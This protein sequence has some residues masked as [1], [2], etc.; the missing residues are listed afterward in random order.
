MLKVVTAKSRMGVLS[1]HH[2]QKHTDD[3][4]K[5]KWGVGEGVEEANFRVWK[6]ENDKKT[7]V[8]ICWKRGR[9]TF[10]TC[11]KKAQLISPG[12]ESPHAVYCQ[13]RDN[14]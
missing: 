1:L 11:K 10:D 5:G 4:L 2:G 13:L 7:R 8:A 9:M 12:N 6:R 3:L 14:N